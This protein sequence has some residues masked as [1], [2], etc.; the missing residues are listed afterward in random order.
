MTEFTTRIQEASQILRVLQALDSR[1]LS[2]KL[3]MIGQ[4]KAAGDPVPVADGS[5]S[6]FTYGNRISDL[7]AQ[8]RRITE[9]KE[10]YMD[11]VLQ[12][13]DIQAKDE[14]SRIE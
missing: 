4:G 13:K 8:K 14:L 11:L 5:N 9:G 3:E 6:V 12:V 1:I 2:I 10:G 7:E